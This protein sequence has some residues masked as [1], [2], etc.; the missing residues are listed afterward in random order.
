MMASSIPKGVQSHAQGGGVG[1]K[2]RRAHRHLGHPKA[3]QQRGQR[4]VH[5]KEE[6]SSRTGT[7]H[8]TSRV[9]D[10]LF[11]IPALYEGPWNQVL[12]HQLQG[13]R[14]LRLGALLRLLRAVVTRRRWI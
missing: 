13:E 8:R 10:V 9:Q 11:H 12:L 5:Q 7:N 3:H 2:H 6:R 1:R 4:G 14:G